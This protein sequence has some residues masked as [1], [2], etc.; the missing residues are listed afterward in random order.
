MAE[1]QVEKALQLRLDIAIKA[2][3]NRLC[4]NFA[5]E[6]IGCVH[7]RSVAEG[8]ARK[9]I[10]QQHER[11]R[12]RACLKPMAKPAARSGVVQVEEAVVE[13]L[14]EFDIFCEPEVRSGLAPKIDNFNR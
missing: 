5:R 14:V 1:R 11:Q 12:A 4:G 10:Q 7:S 9:L 2:G 8:V 13:A 6:L 3:V